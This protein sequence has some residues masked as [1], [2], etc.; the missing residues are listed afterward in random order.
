MEF[1]LF[2][3]SNITTVINAE[4]SCEQRC[5]GNPKQQTLAGVLQFDSDVVYWEIVSDPPDGTLLLPGGGLAS[6]TSDQS[7]S[8]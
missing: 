3:Y 4:D 2:T 8:G 1:F 7:T 6:G 5:G